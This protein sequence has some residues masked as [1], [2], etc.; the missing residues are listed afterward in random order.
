MV[1]ELK[2]SKIDAAKLQLNSAISLYAK[3]DS[4]VSV[5]TLACASYELLIGLARSRGINNVHDDLER[6]I[7]PEKLDEWRR[8]Y[9]SAQNALKHADRDPN[10]LVSL[11]I[12][13]TE[14]KIF[15]ACYLIKPFAQTPDPLQNL[16]VSWYLIQNPSLVLEQYQAEFQPFLDQFYRLGM[17]KKDFFEPFI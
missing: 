7:K 12:H 16:F 4:I 11:T 8:T 15:M 1:V 5:H 3:D 6:R 9:R 10:G 14:V 17:T 13:Q 2:V